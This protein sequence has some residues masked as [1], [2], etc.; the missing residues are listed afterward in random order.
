M[1]TEDKNRKPELLDSGFLATHSN[2]IV[3]NSSYIYTIKLK[4][5]SRK[6]I[7]EKSSKNT[8]QNIKE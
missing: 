3:R 4:T 2:K 7:T 5:E 1:N 6:W 8:Q